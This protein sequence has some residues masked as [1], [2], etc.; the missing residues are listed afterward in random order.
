M[1]WTPD[2]LSDLSRKTYV[3]TGGNS[4]LG[5]EA[6][7]ILAGKNARVVITARS[8]AKA[9]GA[10]ATLRE[11]VPDADLDYVLLDLADLDSV[12][13][14]APEIREKAPTIDAFINN[15]GVMQ[16]PELR[17]QRGFELQFGTN[18]LGHFK[19]NSRLVDHFEASGT[20]I[21]PVSSIAHKYGTIDLND[22]NSESASYSPSTA[23][24]QSKL[25]NI[26]Y[27]FE[28]NRRLQA[29]GSEAV[30]IPCH[31]GYAATNLQ[32]AGVGMDGG[33]VL[34]RWLY[35]VTNV[36]WAQSAEKGA[37]PLVLAAAGEARPGAY[38]GP[39]G[40]G[41]NFGPVGE[42]YIHPR[43]KDEDVARKLWEASEQMVG[44][45]FPETAARG[46]AL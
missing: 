27:G 5:L 10:L 18:H 2:Q 13:R 15:A 6:A 23:Y 31:P 17:T 22:V 38:Y 20:R 11:T 42:S 30:A 19:L 29:R 24:F 32:S 44:A 21:V 36:L 28:L 8:E 3:I 26:M 14:A 7:T 40:W 43:A 12:E 41:Q 25:A 33:S 35:R 39:T 4:G 45:F 34:F 46:S 9:T 1:G 37:Y 16:T